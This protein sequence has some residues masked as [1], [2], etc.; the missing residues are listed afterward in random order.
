VPHP[1]PAGSPLPL[2]LTASTSTSH[3]AIQVA[4]REDE[5]LRT[6]VRESL[7]P[8]ALT[9][10]TSRV[11][12]PSGTYRVVDRR[13]HDSAQYTDMVIVEDAQGNPID[14]AGVQAMDLESPER[15]Q[16]PSSRTVDVRMETLDLGG[17][18]DDADIIQQTQASQA[19]RQA[20]A[21][22]T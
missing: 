9:P 14:A 2:E 6:R 19:E 21:V 5:D 15:E 12:Q 10:L 4:I 3:D 1:T 7:G 18:S 8:A 16:L 11:G 22:E 17:E 13:G 20:E